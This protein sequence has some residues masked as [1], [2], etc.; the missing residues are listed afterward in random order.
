LIA[1]GNN[2]YGSVNGVTTDYLKVNNLNI[3]SGRTFTEFEYNQGSAV[4]ILGTN[5][6]ET[7]FPDTD[8]L[9]QQLRMGNIILTVIGVLSSEG[10][11]FG[12]ADNS[13]LVPLTTMQ[14][15]VAQPRTANGG[16]GVS[17]I[18]L[19]IADQ[20]YA[21]VVNDEISSLLRI[22][23]EIS[24]NG[25]DDFSISS[26]A[27]LV[28]TVSETANTLTLLLGAVAA[29]SLLVGGIGVMNIMLVSVLERTREIGI[30][31]ALGARDR[32]IWT[33][34]LTEAAILTLAG[35]IIGVIF[36]CVV[37]II[38]S[39]V[40]AINTLIS[41]A[42]IIMAVSVSVAIGLFFGFYPA[43]NASRLDPIEALRSE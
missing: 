6:K 10:D 12:S 33:Q 4:A 38:V 11:S 41:P 26:M 28:E 3:S 18:S 23:H 35:G 5:V 30:R 22:R 24:A 43:W 25:E 36:G 19:E 13:I 39:H 7:L 8:P 32:D 15:T 20:S 34:F 37:S 1:S 2:M 16:H 29:I 42:I 9:Q 14:Q 17:T 31:K 21:D 40:A 27:E